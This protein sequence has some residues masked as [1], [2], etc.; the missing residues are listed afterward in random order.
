MKVSV[1]ILTYNRENYLKEAVISVLN[2]TFED[3]ELIIL[4][5]GST[6]DTA[7]MVEIFSDKRLN[8]YQFEHVGNGAKL[9]NKGVELAKGKYIAYL[10]SDDL[11]EEHKLKRQVQILD[12]DDAIGFTFS[13]VKSFN[14]LTGTNKLFYAKN[15]YSSYSKIL[16]K[17]LFADLIIYPSSVLI[18]KDMILK[19]GGFSEKYKW[20]EMGLLLKIAVGSDAFY[21]ETILTKVRKHET[22]LSISNDFRE[23]FLDLIETINELKLKKKISNDKANKGL[24][25]YYKY[26]AFSYSY[27][28]KHKEARKYIYKAWKYQPFDSGILKM[29]L[30]ILLKQNTGIKTN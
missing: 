4:D 12:S 19:E 29:I 5:D 22:N 13:Q 15:I 18:R 3:F 21:D 24:G 11:W 26:F 17:L 27:F 25:K 16:D 1:I 30:R 8:Y 20:T 6:D 28:E 7:E 9:R 14:D 2:Q 23:G 10:D